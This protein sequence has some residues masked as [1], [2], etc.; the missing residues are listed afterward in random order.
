MPRR[1][2]LTTRLIGT[3]RCAG[4]R[5]TDSTGRTTLVVESGWLT[6]LPN[7][8]MHVIV[9]CDAKKSDPAT[10]AST[11][12]SFG[13]H[14]TWTVDEAS[15]VVTHFLVGS[16]VPDWLWRELPRTIELD[17]SGSTLWLG[18]ALDNQTSDR[19]DWDGG[20]AVVE[21]R[22]VDDAAAEPSLYW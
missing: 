22:R 18:V 15:A 19:L 17:E 9:T 6:Y 5:A 20:R 21:W 1:D 4:A 16:T 10:L 14:G 3:W 2:D 7:G 11:G 12:V 13:Y 8:Q